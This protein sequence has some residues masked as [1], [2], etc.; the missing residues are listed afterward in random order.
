MMI[1]RTKPNVW[2]ILL[3]EYL[4][5]IYLI[6]GHLR[7]V[8]L[9]YSG[10]SHYFKKM[11]F[12][13]SRSNLVI[14]YNKISTLHFLW[15]YDLTYSF[16]LFIVRNLKEILY[17]SWR[18]LPSTALFPH[19]YS[20]LLGQVNQNIYMSVRFKLSGFKLFKSIEMLDGLHL[21]L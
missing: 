21:L 15:E 6:L 14:T 16:S 18:Q 19:I 5:E 13:I 4:Q 7:S 10:G 2:R 9:L 11:Q 20:P 17:R 8:M 3:G 12:Q 1:L